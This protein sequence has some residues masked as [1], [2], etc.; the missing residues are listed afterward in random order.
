M[1]PERNQ[2]HPH[3]EHPMSTIIDNNGITATVHNLDSEQTPIYVMDDGAW[4]S[5]FLTSEDAS[6]KEVHVRYTDKNGV[7][8]EDC[9]PNNRDTLRIK[10]PGGGNAIARPDG[11]LDDLDLD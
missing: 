10:L 5:G 7:L 11:H 9:I 3:L 4:C 6:A 8:T 2:G 1:T